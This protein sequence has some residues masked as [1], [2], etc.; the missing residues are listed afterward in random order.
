MGN[1]KTKEN[2]LVYSGEKKNIKAQVHG[3]SRVVLNV[4]NCVVSKL[5][6]L[7]TAQ[8]VACGALSRLSEGDGGSAWLSLSC[9]ERQCEM[10]V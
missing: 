1:R 10:R 4:V 8:C 7:A 6:M 9:V 5:F 3:R 2:A